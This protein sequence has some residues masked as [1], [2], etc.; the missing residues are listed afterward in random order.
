M[1][2]RACVT[3]FPAAGDDQSL[4]RSP[5]T[6]GPPLLE[7]LRVAA[8]QPE[9]VLEPHETLPNALLRRIDSWV[10][11]LLGR[12]LRFLLGAALLALLAIWMDAKGIVTVSQGRDQVA[13]LYRVSR[14][15]V[16][17]A[18]PNFFRQL[19]WNIPYSLGVAAACRTSGFPLAC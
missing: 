4:E 14:G 2:R 3:C 16:E 10:G 8:S 7:R 13:E 18:D 6:H 9:P 5:A 15:A 12:R 1:S 19:K 11:I 17:S